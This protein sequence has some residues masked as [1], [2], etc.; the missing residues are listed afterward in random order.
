MACDRCLSSQ[1]YDAGKYF[2]MSPSQE[3]GWKVVVSAEGGVNK[4][5]PSA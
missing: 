4:D 1:V 2:T 3:E 5:D